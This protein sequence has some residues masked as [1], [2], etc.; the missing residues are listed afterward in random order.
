[1]GV[2]CKADDL[3]LQKKKKYIFGKSKEVKTG[4]DL[5]ESSKA[6]AHEVPVS[7]L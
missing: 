1:L 6:I 2:G 3:N 7:Q 5:T 4:S